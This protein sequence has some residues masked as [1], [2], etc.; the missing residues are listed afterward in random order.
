MPG[1]FFW[2]DLVT[3]DPQA[4]RRFYADVIGWDAMESGAPDYSLFTAAGQPVTGLMQIPPDALA[5]GARPFWEGYIAVD[6]VD[7]ATDQVV[8]AGGT[9]HHPPTEVPGIIRFAILADPQGALFVLAKGL[10][11]TPPPPLPVGT[12]GTIGWRELYATDMPAALAFYESL[13]GWTRAEAMDMGPVGIYQQFAIDGRV[14]GG[15]MTRPATMPKSRW[16]YYIYVPAIDAAA[17]RVTAGGGA[18]V[19]GPHEVPGGQWVVHGTDPQGALFA[20]VAPVR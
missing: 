5:A 17:A 8:R 6:D 4:A 3:T 20:L 12:P 19:N 14:M 1:N 10:N 11:P 13:F 15:M 7:A 16:N 18:I 9:C 2:Y